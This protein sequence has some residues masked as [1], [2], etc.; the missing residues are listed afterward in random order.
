ML[1]VAVLGPL[2]SQLMDFIFIQHTCNHTYNIPATYV[3]N[4]CDMH[5]ICMQHV[6]DPSAVWLAAAV[7]R[8]LQSQLADLIFMHD[9]L[10]VRPHPRHACMRASLLCPST[11]RPVGVRVHKRAF[12]H[13]CARVRMCVHVCVYVYVHACV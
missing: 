1:A 13:T 8:F 3:P 12:V 10:E 7:S 9:E 6:Q 5:V 4:S 11:Y 2:H